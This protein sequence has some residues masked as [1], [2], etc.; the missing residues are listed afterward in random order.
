MALISDIGAGI[1]TQLQY[2]TRTTDIDTAFNAV[3]AAD[4]NT[5]AQTAYDVT[6]TGLKA[7]FTS[8]TTVGEIRDFPSFGTPAN[9]VNV[10]N[11]GQS[12]SSQIQGQ[13]DAPTLE[14]TLNY[15]P[16][17][18]AALHDLAAAGTN[19]LFKMNIRNADTSTA[20]NAAFFVQGRI[21]AVAVA[22]NLT[23]SN[24]ATLTLLTTSD[25]VGPLD[26]NS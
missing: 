20:D 7:E 22:P 5:A 24:Q 18:H 13:A 2:L 1:Y 23:D 14:F 19:L 25:Y 26:D 9:I 4:T 16:D 6:D 21:A 15:T 17:D 3:A 12:V 10:P 11:Y 8:Q